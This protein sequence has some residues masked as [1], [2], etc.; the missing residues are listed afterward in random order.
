[1][2]T[3]K[4]QNFPVIY[5]TGN[6]PICFYFKRYFY[7]TKILIT[8]YCFV[9]LFTYIFTPQFFSLCS[10]DILCYHIWISYSNS[11]QFCSIVH[12]FFYISSTYPHW[13]TIVTRLYLWVVLSIIK[14]IF[15]RKI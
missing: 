8:L 10:C 11:A 14:F 4:K 6:T 12:V 7:E 2:Q 3:Y 13:A 15:Y 5:L 1:M 9:C